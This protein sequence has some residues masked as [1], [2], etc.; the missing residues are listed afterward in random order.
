MLFKQFPIMQNTFG[1]IVFTLQV[2]VMVQNS[3]MYFK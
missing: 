2:R 3:I 1:M